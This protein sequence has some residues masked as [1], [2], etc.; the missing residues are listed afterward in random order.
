VNR[1]IARSLIVL[2]GVATTLL[3]AVILPA[4]AHEERTIGP[5]HLAVGFGEE[6][7]YAGVENSV[8]MFLH[9]KNDKP[10]IDLGPTLKVQV[11][12]GSRKTT[13][14]TMEPN[15]EIG[16]FGIPGDYR[17]FFI[18]TA[19]GPYTF[20]LFG[21]IK[22]QKVNS[23]FTSGP[24]TFAVVT[25]PSSVEFPVKAPTNAELGTA[26]SR[27]APRVDQAAGVA[28]AA[29][30]AATSANDAASSAKT[31]G[32]IGIIAGVIGLAVGTAALVVATRR[33]GV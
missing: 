27:L 24:S 31:F 15:F 26:V 28:T 4:S 17:A 13:P 12:F 2:L 14:M 3:V 16:E 32:I 1:A 11:I 20:H 33:R 10:V 6:P 21:S 29:H 5:Y 25:D 19:P 30:A 18:P 7:A 23:S 9:D 22:G 8:Q